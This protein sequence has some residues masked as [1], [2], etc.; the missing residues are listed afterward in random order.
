MMAFTRNKGEMTGDEAFARLSTLCAK[1]E[2]STGE[3][4]QRMMRWGLDADTQQQV[5]DALVDARFV[6]D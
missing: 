6:D 4:R 1:G 5:V 2:H 3:M